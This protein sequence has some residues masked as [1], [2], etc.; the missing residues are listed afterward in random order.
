MTNKQKMPIG[1]IV[2]LMERG[3]ITLPAKYRKELDLS[4]G[5]FL[6][7]F[8][9]KDFLVVVPIEMKPKDKKGLTKPA[10]WTEDTP[11]EYM[12]KVRYNPLEELWARRLREEW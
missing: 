6:N 8:V 1:E 10:D 12:K 9:W 11:E 5:E 4:E 3:T 7:V 2:K